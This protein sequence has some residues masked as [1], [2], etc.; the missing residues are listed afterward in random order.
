[1][2]RVTFKNRVNRR[3]LSN[4][5]NARTASKSHTLNL[6]TPNNRPTRENLIQSAIKT[7]KHRRNTLKRVNGKYRK[8]KV[9]EENNF[10]IASNSLMKMK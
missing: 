4:N 8:S 1:M 2:K 5:E 9:K 7:A 6:S 10:L 3:N